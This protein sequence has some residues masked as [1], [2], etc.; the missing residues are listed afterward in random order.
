MRI[1]VGFALW[2]LVFWGFGGFRYNYPV[3]RCDDLGWFDK[4]V[5]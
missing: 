1:S 4:M 2:K 3:R 5:Q